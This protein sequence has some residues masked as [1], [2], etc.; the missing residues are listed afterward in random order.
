MATTSQTAPVSKPII[1]A[2]WIIGIVAVAFLVMSGVMKL[3]RPDLFVPA[4]TNFGYDQSVIRPLGVVQIVCTVLYLFRAR[5][6]Q[7][8]ALNWLHGIAS[9]PRTCAPSTLISSS[10]VSGFCFG[11]ASTCATAA[12]A[13]CFHC[14]VNFPRKQRGRTWSIPN[15]TAERTDAVDRAGITILRIVQ[16]PSRP[17]N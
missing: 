10:S 4:F 3:V 9:S 13:R 16:A 15:N 11:W 17:G 1:L 12:S 14:E 2:G 7:R 6:T 5:R 8:C